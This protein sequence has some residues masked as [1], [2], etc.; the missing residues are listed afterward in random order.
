MGFKY[1]NFLA[2]YSLASLRVG[3]AQVDDASYN[4]LLGDEF[5]ADC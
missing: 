4:D 3:M 2:I 1:L 5:H